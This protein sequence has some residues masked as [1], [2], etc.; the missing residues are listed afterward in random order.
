[1][2]LKLSPLGKASGLTAVLL[3]SL[4]GYWLYTSSPTIKYARLEEFADG[5]SFTE[6]M[7]LRV[8][9]I[10]I[11]E[12]SVMD[13]FRNPEQREPTWWE[14]YTLKKREITLALIR[15]A[16]VEELRRRLAERHADRLRVILHDDRDTIWK[17]IWGLTSEDRYNKIVDIVLAMPCEEITRI[18]YQSIK[19]SINSKIKQRIEEER[20]TDKRI[21]LNEVFELL[22]RDQIEPYIASLDATKKDDPC[23]KTFQLLKWLRGEEA[24]GFEFAQYQINEGLRGLLDQVADALIEGKTG[25]ALHKLTVKVIGYTD[26]VP[27]TKDGIA[28]QRDKTG[29]D[30][31]SKVENP[32]DVHYSAC[33]GDRQAGG[34]PIYIALGR[35]LGK[36]IRDKIRSNCELGAVRAYVGSVYLMNK[37]GRTGIEYSYAT[38]GIYLNPGD[39]ADLKKRRINIELT[40]KAAKAGK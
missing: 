20:E 37:L 19:E 23:F 21:D 11:G 2:A 13:L 35:P 12:A 33:V 10:R 6:Q 32:L 15:R 39:T 9:D 26:P 28:L 36:R 18:V 30:D 25:W 1:M 7:R 24:S 14:Y 3:A 22:L 40:V 16:D 38:G 34:D 31:W 17:S 4:F 27:V 29:I 5:V 8:K